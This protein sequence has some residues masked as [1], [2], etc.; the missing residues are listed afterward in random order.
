MYFFM[1]K[2]WASI[3]ASVRRKMKGRQLLPFK[4]LKDKRQS[5][6]AI[7]EF[8]LLLVVL[9]G[10]TWAFVIFMNRNLSKYWQ[11]SINL[12]VNDKPGQTT[13]RIQ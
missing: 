10:I 12:I 13:H 4:F 1:R 7:I 3:I 2:P 5:G 6:Q 8:A 11:A 9:T